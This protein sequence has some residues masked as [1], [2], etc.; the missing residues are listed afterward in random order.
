[1][2][3]GDFTVKRMRRKN[4]SVFL[5]AEN[6]SF[7]SVSGKD[8]GKTAEIVPGSTLG[9]SALHQTTPQIAVQ[10]ASRQSRSHDPRGRSPP[11]EKNLSKKNTNPAPTRFNLVPWFSPSRLACCRGGRSRWR[12]PRA[13]I[14][15]TFPLPPNQTAIADVLTDM[16]AEL[17]AWSSGRKRPAPSSRP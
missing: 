12:Q 15:R 8:V 11:Q 10:T 9:I 17:A 4:D 1:M 7:P 5:E 16:D 14:V 6:D 2:L 13:I 3:D